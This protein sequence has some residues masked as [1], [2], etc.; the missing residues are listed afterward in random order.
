MGGV[1]LLSSYFTELCE[2]KARHEPRVIHESST[3]DNPDNGAEDKSDN[4]DDTSLVFF[5][6]DNG[7]CITATTIYNTGITHGSEN[8]SSGVT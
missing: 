4:K 2:F 8:V 6:G 1:T 3:I 5:I 7:V